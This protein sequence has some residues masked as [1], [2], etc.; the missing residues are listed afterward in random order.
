VI[1]TLLG[2]IKAVIIEGEETDDGVEEKFPGIIIPCMFNPEDYTV[3]QSNSYQQVYENGSDVP[4]MN[5]TGAGERILKLNTLYFD[6]YELP[7]P[8]DVSLITR[9]LWDLMKPSV[10]YQHENE[11][12][13]KP[14]PVIF[15]WGLFEFYAV[16][17]SCSQKFTLFHHTGM[18]LRAEVTV[19]FK[20]HLKTDMY[21]GLP[22]NPTSGGGPIERIWK[23]KAGDRLDL[24]ADRVYKDSTKWRLIADRNGISNPLSIRAGQNLRIPP[25]SAG[26]S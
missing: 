22:Q 17:T 2:L 13:K 8:V 15:R 7:I 6:T 3:S 4:K 23:V 16:M 10:E 18:P 14:P 21:V 20:Q 24:I 1:P 26:I 19:E 11:T 12:K 5:F 9:W 25:K